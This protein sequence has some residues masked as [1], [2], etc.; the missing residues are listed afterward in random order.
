MSSWTR[1]C[2]RHRTSFLVA[3]AMDLAITLVSVSL[4]TQEP[5]LNQRTAFVGWSIWIRQIRRRSRPIGLDVLIRVRHTR[6]N[7]GSET[8]KAPIGGFGRAQFRSAMHRV[9]SANG[10]VLAPISTIV[11]FWNN[12]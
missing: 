12:P 8:E 6:R 7:T 3:G 9:R 11:S 1:F 10:T 5:H 2:K 4:N